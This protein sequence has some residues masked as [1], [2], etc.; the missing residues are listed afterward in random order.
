MGVGSNEDHRISYLLADERAGDDDGDVHARALRAVKDRGGGGRSWSGSIEGVRGVFVVGE[1][2]S[3][4][5]QA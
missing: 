3:R 1:P 2:R 4:S 5:R